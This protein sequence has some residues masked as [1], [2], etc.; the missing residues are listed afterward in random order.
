MSDLLWRPAKT[1]RR[2]LD[3][4]ALAAHV[5]D[6]RDTLLRDRATHFG[7]IIN[8]ILVA[9]KTLLINKKTTNYLAPFVRLDFRGRLGER[10][11]V[12]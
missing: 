12:R 5:R 7:L 9:L 3:K 1:C 2:K 6:F 10:R 4:A 8:A 11:L